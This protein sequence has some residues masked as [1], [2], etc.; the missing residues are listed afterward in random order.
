MLTV[1]SDIKGIK[2]HK[3]LPV[4]QTVSHYSYTDVLEGLRGKRTVAKER[5]YGSTN[6]I[7]HSALS[8]KQFFTQKNHPPY[9]P[10]LVY[11]E[12]LCLENNI[13]IKESHFKEVEHIKDGTT[14]NLKNVSEEG[15]EGFEAWK[16]GTE[17]CFTTNRV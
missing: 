17:N 16:R 2:P 7:C 4:G 11:C 12:F 14:E 9:S 6:G 15:F 8:V 3:C 1:F 10:N 13:F 5:S